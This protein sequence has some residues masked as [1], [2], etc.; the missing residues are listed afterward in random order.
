M[1]DE[2][3][4]KD[5]FGAVVDFSPQEE[6][7][8][9]L[10]DK[11]GREFNIFTLTDALGARNKKEAWTLYQKALAA[12][13][14]AD[15]IFFKIFWQVKSMLLASKTKSVSETDMKPFTYNKSKSFT[16]NFKQEELEKLS[17][18][19]VTGFIL[20]RRG[21]GEIETLLEKIL[22]KL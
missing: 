9:P 7:E 17:E 15:E 11:K 22:L 8:K 19:L 18:D 12:G 21:E 13:V 20:A 10:L 6:E 5:L 4:H 2:F 1:K 3:Y 16:N 14:S